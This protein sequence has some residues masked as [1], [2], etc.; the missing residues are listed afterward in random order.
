MQW[1]LKKTKLNLATALF[2]GVLPIVPQSVSSQEDDKSLQ[3]QHALRAGKYSG[4]Q[5]STSNANTACL[6]SQHKVLLKCL[7]VK[8]CLQHSQITDLLVTM[9]FCST[10]SKIDYE[11]WRM[12][13]RTV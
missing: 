11:L 9:I 7:F 4:M 13:G 10:S 12:R 3:K 5:L 1:V 2:S 6:P 8:L